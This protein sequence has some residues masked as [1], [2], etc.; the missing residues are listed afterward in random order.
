MVQDLAG[1]GRVP[2]AFTI[3]PV[4]DIH[5]G[6][7]RSIARRAGVP[8]SLAT[9]WLCADK[10]AGAASAAPG[11]QSLCREGKSKGSGDHRLFEVLTKHCLNCVP[12]EGNW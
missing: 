2:C 1:A 12:A 4:K 9:C 11:R 10:K 3:Y 8:P 7:K 5:H 6:R